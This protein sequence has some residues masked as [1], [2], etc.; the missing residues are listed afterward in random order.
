MSLVVRPPAVVPP[1]APRTAAWPVDGGEYSFE[2]V[3]A[4]Q[5]GEHAAHAEGS[6]HDRAHDRLPHAQAVPTHGWS[7]RLDWTTQPW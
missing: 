6:K 3:Q 5:R 2:P 1:G 4:E 7:T